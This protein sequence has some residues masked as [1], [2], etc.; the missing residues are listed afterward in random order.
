MMRHSNG[1]PVRVNN[2]SASSPTSRGQMGASSLEECGFRQTDKQT[3][4]FNPIGKLNSLYKA[5]KEPAQVSP[6]SCFEFNSASVSQQAS[7]CLL[8]AS[9]EGISLERAERQKVTTRRR[10]SGAGRWGAS[11]CRALLWATSGTTGELSRLLRQTR[12]AVEWRTVAFF[13][14]NSNLN[15]ATLD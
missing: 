2:E 5:T 14:Y 9:P 3:G 10:Q 1:W 6:R 8:A 13:D 12:G 11:A 4:S 7:A 15:L